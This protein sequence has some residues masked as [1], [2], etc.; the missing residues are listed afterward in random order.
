[1]RDRDRASDVAVT[2]D[3]G[4]DIGERRSRSPLRQHEDRN[5][6]RRIEQLVEIRRTCG[7]T[8]VAKQAV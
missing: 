8:A 5:L 2:A 6:A 4:G 1:M 7:G 3:R